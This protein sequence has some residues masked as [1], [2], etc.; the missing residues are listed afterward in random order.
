MRKRSLS[1][2]PYGDGPR[3]APLAS[4]GRF[5]SVRD[6]P[7]GRGHRG[8]SACL[9][10][11]SLMV[12]LGG[13]SATAFGLSR[14]SVFVQVSS[15]ALAWLLFVPATFAAAVTLVADQLPTT[16]QSPA[17]PWH[18]ERLSRFAFPALSTKRAYAGVRSSRV[19]ELVSP[20]RHG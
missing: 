11:S 14:P 4:L 5:R 17:S 1:H 18:P 9:S 20:E 15:Q 19:S 6:D 16:A 2:D 3:L 13:L 8:R 7:G 10:R 12:V